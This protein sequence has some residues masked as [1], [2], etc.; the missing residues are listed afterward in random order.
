M[1]THLLT[2]PDQYITGA[3]H[4]LRK[5]SLDEL[6]QLYSILR[7]HRGIIGMTR[8]SLIFQVLS[9]FKSALF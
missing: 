1:P 9:R 4:F 8:K 5:T 2:N 3:G 6:L 7:G